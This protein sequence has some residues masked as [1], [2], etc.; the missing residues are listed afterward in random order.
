MKFSTLKKALLALGV[1]TLLS[2]FATSCGNTMYGMGLDLERTGRR[3][4]TN[5]DPNAGDPYNDGSGA[6]YNQQ[7]PYTANPYGY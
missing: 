1:L 2:F 5:H 6:G 4:Q 7:Q 3:L